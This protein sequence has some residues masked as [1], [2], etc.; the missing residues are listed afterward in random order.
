MLTA[1]VLTRAVGQGF[2]KPPVIGPPTDA[3]VIRALPRPVR[4]IP[5]VAEVFRDDI[6]IVK[7]ARPVGVRI[8]LPGGVGLRLVSD[9]WMC[10]VY[11]TMRMRVNLPGLPLEFKRTRDHTVA[12][13]KWE[14]R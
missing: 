10:T 9:R 4:A 7:T 8:P 14:L 3:Q 5:R 11:H 1:L 6:V 12:F 2:A 13:D